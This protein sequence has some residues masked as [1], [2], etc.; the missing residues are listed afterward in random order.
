VAGTS[1]I[2]E[3]ADASGVARPDTYRAVVELEKKG[4]I[5]KT[6]SA[7]PDTPFSRSVK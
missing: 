6:V 1:T 5:E 3:T 7:R 4:L 2:R